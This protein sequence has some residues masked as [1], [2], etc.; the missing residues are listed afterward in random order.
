MVPTREHTP[1]PEQGQVDCQELLREKMRLA[2]RMTLTTVLDEELAQVIGAGR[3]ERNAARR[4]HRNDSYRRDLV[5]TAD[6]IEG[7]RSHQ[8]CQESCA[9]HIV[10]GHKAVPYILCSYLGHRTQDSCLQ[11]RA[12]VACVKHSNSLPERL[13][14]C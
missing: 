14:G 7:F 2:I 6:L 9:P 12:S 8:S 5:T 13:D 4:D 11:Y 3:F 1:E 10:V